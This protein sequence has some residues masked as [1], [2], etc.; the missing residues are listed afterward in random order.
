MTF[1]KFATGAALAIAGLMAA[2]GIGLLANSISGDNVGL[3]AEP[4]SAGETL[5]PASATK[6]DDRSQKRTRTRRRNRNRGGNDGQA[7]TVT[8]PPSS[9]TGGTVTTFDDHGGTS[10]GSGSDDGGTSGSSG[11]SGSGSSGSGSTPGGSGSGDSSGP[12][13]AARAARA[14][15]AA[16]TTTSSRAARTTLTRARARRLPRFHSR[17][18]V[19]KGPHGPDCAPERSAPGGKVVWPPQQSPPVLPDAPSGGNRSARPWQS[20]PCWC[21]VRPRRMPPRRRTTTSLTR[22][23]LSNSSLPVTQTASNVEATRETEEP[24]HANIDGGGSLWWRWTAAKTGTITIDTCGSDLDTLLGI[25]TGTSV[26]ALTEVASSDD[27]AGHRCGVASGT[28][29][30]AQAGTTYSIAVDGSGGDTGDVTLRL[31]PPPANDDFADAATLPGDQPYVIATNLFAGSEPGEPLH[32]G[33]PAV[34]SVWWRWVA[35]YDG[36]AQMQACG[37]TF[38]PV[39]AVYTGTA[40]DQLTQVASGRGL[41]PGYP[42]HLRDSRRD[43]VPDRRRQPS[44][45]SHG[46]D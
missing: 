32:A 26:D 17:R 19:V 1:R 18:R 10:G 6:A 4:L 30:R 45:G 34:H 25:Y 3:G 44:G 5:A 35:P 38:K 37:I 23:T 24:E 12:A 16:R 31:E 33:F 36:T 42:R 2:V 11:S 13:P 41:R 43:G 9:G 7:D 28:N 15:P 20:Q 27:A 39:L 14:T 40:V 21:S 8:V 22:S 29:F 46:D